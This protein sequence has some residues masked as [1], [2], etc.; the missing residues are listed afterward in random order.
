MTVH[1][2]LLTYRVTAV[3]A[4]NKITAFSP[5]FLRSSCSGSAAQ[6]RNVTTSLAICEAVAGVPFHWISKWSSTITLPY[7]LGIQLHRRREPAP[8]RWL[9]QGNMGYNSSL[10]GFQPRQ[11]GRHIRSKVKRYNP[12]PDVWGEAVGKW[13]S[14]VYA[15]H[16]H[17]VL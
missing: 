9:L 17:D 10:H 6:F 12:I 4:E 5:I 14:F 11:G 1:L 13:K 7:H 16:H 8:W 3:N 2:N 15:P